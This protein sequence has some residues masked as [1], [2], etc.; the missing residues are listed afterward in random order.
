MATLT[1]DALERMNTISSTMLRN[2]S[3]L[4]LRTDDVTEGV[5]AFMDEREPEF[6]GR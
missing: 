1:P 5:A 3:G 4:L 2:I 6:R